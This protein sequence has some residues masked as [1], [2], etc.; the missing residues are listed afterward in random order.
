MIT[1]N[2]RR[3]I[4][5]KRQRAQLVYNFGGYCSTVS[6]IRVNAMNEEKQVKPDEQSLGSH[7]SVE[8]QD[9]RPGSPEK[10]SRMEVLK[11]KF[12]HENKELLD[13]FKLAA[14]KIHPVVQDDTISVDED[15]HVVK[16]DGS[17]QRKEAMS[18]ADSSA[19]DDNMSLADESAIEDVLNNNVA[20]RKIDNAG[21][22]RRRARAARAI[23]NREIRLSEKQVMQSILLAEE[24]ALKGETEF[25][26]WRKVDDL[27]TVTC[28]YPSKPDRMLM[29]VRQLRNQATSF[30]GNGN[31]DQLND[32]KTFT[33]PRR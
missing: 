10:M 20:R 16:D 1:G 18:R 26:T 8:S 13:K 31:V 33:E 6:N 29:R 23:A 25:Q 17:N 27:K 12:Q 30:F 15:D 5:T 14:V 19:M 21:S 24:A 2:R 11:D 4:I 32:H 9:Y 22:T 7:V 28:T 3:Q